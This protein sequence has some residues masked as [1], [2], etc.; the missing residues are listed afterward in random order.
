MQFDDILYG[1]ITIKNPIIQSIV[2]TDAFQ[3][4]KEINQYGGVNFLYKDSYQ[5]TRF[6]HSIGVW[7]ILATVGASIEVQIA[8]LIHDIGHAA[9]SHMVDH[10]L[11]DED[12]HHDSAH[13]LPGIAEV[14][15]IIEKAGVTLKNDLDDYTEIKAKLPLVGADRIDYAMRDYYAVIGHKEGFGK[16]VLNNLILQNGKILFTDPTICR[17]FAL[18]GTDALTEL[19][20][21]PEIAPIYAALMKMIDQGLQKEIIARQDLFL[22]DKGLF[23]KL[24]NAR[25]QLDQ[26]SI[27]IF[28]EKF[29]VESGTQ[30][31]H[32]FFQTSDKLRYFDPELFI[33]GEIK[34]LSKIDPEFKD[35][36]EIKVQ[37]IHQ[38]QK[39]E[40]F[41][42]IFEN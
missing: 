34:T 41:K 24:M 25:D 37:E 13:L 23:N 18:D 22:T 5:T 17:E 29:R 10:V 35:T 1:K 38:R 32:D 7:H 9:F 14:H 20:Y 27:K 33:D 12:F 6:E 11:T 39:G 31:D 3:R 36:F 28:E 8:G 30:Q 42:V 40:Y 15:N 2:A 21:A 26:T 4:L 19:V 16:S